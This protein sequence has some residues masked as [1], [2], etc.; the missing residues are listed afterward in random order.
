MGHWQE[1]FGVIIV[2]DAGP[3]L[4]L[5]WV[6]ASSWALPPHSIDVVSEIWEEVESPAPAALQDARLR[7]VSVSVPV[8]QNLSRWSLDPGEQTALNY[9]L[10][11]RSEQ[12]VLVLCDA[13]QARRACRE[14]S[15]PVVGSI[16]LITEAFRAS[17][18]SLETASAALWNLPG[19]GRL[20]IRP[21]LIERVLVALEES[22]DV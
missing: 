9:A 16:G 21:Q 7:R 19:I 12:D 10:S 20:H 1:V 14:L 5:F 3:L 22:R 11:Q 2:A 4:H 13:R 6:G 8:S 18:V 17:R 15:L